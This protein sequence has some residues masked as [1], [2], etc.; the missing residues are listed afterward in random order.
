MAQWNEE[1]CQGFYS[2]FQEAVG[3][4]DVHQ[5]QLSQQQDVLQK[6]VDKFRWEQD[7]RIQV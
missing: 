2:Y 1:H 6:K 5:L 7:N 3:L 4:W